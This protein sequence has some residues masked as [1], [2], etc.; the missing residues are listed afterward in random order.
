M[1]KI[2]K[3]LSAHLIRMCAH[4]SEYSLVSHVLMHKCFQIQVLPCYKEIYCYLGISYVSVATYLTWMYH[5]SK[6]YQN[7]GIS[8]VCPGPYK[9]IPNGAQATLGPDA[10][11]PCLALV[12]Q[13]VIKGFIQSLEIQIYT[14]TADKPYIFCLGTD[15]SFW[16]CAF[17]YR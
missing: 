11:S 4:Y 5:I 6:M 15:F 10:T 3:T 1:F 7:L 2:L 9:I 12:N 17:S 8:Y 13:L 16:L 14:Q